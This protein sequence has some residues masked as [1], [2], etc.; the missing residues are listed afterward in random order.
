MLAVCAVVVGGSAL[1]WTVAPRSERVTGWLVAV[2]R[3]ACARLARRVPAL[4]ELDPGRGLLDVRTSLRVVARRPLGL[5]ARTAVAQSIGAVILLVALRGLGVGEE[6]GLLEFARVYFV[7]TLLSSFVPVPGG[8]GVVEAGLTGCLLQPASTAAGA[9]AGVLVFRLMTYV[10][11]IVVGAVLYVA[12]RLDVVRRASPAGAAREQDEGWRRPGI[13]LREP[14]AIEEVAGRERCA[15]RQPSRHS[16]PVVA[17]MARFGR[18]LTAM[19][20]PFDAHGQLDVDA[21]VTLAKWL[22]EQE[23][24]GLG[25]SGTTVQPPVLSIDEKLTLFEAVVD[26]VT[27]R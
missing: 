14:A 22:V 24:E 23:N 10:A 4:T 1:F 15:I 16:A 11:P 8:V 25:V 3:R 12:W 20:T 27:V 5:L 26:A 19:V 13:E 18:A 6:L 21:A 9:L 17:L 2:T 7:V